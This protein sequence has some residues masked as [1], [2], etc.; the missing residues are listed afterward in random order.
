MKFLKL[1]LAGPMQSWGDHSRWDSRDTAAAPTKSAVI[2]LL[3]CC[4]GYKRGDDR[5][6]A[7]S[8]DIRMAVRTDSP[9]TVMTDFHTVQGTDG[10]I[11]NAKGKKRSVGSTIITPRH[12]LQDARFTVFLWG[13][14]ER[15]SECAESLLHPH[16]PPFLGRKSC[17]P[18]VPLV[19]EWVEADS[20]D[21]AV[22]QLTPEEWKRGG[23]TR[24]VQ[25]EMR[26]GE[27]AGEDENVIER[28]DNV[29]RADIN[30]YAFRRI[31]VRRISK[32]GESCDF[33]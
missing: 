12:Y 6:R 24:I 9:G 32:G 25:I 15:L 11:L 22:A 30:E 31:R 28:R 27:T 14:E 8:E 16:W 2:G 10:V 5:L 20:I 29:V 33:Q 21:D 19:P 7:L 4:L 23:N 18:S 3:G 26:T 17:T 13:E 1:V